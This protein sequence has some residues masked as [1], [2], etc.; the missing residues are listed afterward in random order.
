MLPEAFECMDHRNLFIQILFDHSVG[1]LLFAG[2][3]PHGAA[4][5]AS[6]LATGLAFAATR[7]LILADSVRSYNFDMFHKAPP[8]FMIL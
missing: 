1:L 2:L 4:R 7:A 3:V 5:L 6:G 8:I